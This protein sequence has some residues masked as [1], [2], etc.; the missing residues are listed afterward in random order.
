MGGF[1]RV[2]SFGPADVD[3]AFLRANRSILGQPRGD[4]YWLWKPYFVVRILRELRPGDLLFYCDSGSHFVSSAQGLFDLMTEER[5]LLVFELEHLERHWT[6]RDAF[7]LLD[8]DHASYA[9]TRQRQGGYQLWRCSPRALEMAAEY[10]ALA[11]DPR[12]LTDQ[13][14]QCGLPNYDGFVEHRHDQS[15][16][17]L[18]SNKWGIEAFRDPTQWGNDT[19]RLN[20]SYPQVLESTR[21]RRWDPPLVGRLRRWLP[22][23]FH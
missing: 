5:P 17:S 15:L 12:L 19:Q 13:P 22:R 10:L 1:D 23:R 18:L 2:V 7:L 3:R 8:C 20:S 16:L 21:A 4:G 6:K 11:Q 9:E 14:N